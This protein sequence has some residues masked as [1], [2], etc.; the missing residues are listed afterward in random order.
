MST[1]I[2]ECVKEISR[3]QN[4]E[5]LL[6][7]YVRQ[8]ME[9]H[10]HH[11]KLMLMMEYYTFYEMISE[12][13][14]PYIDTAKDN[15]A[16]LHQV[17]CGIFSGEESFSDEKRQDLEKTLLALRAEVTEKMKVLTA[18]IDCFVIYEYVLNRVQYRFE[19]QEMMPEDTVFAQEVLNFIFS[20]KDNVV[21]NDNIRMVL[22]QLPVRMTRK[23]YLD[24]VR[25]SISVYEGSD[26]ASL[27]GH[28]YMFRTCA[29]LYETSSMEKYFTEFVPV[30]RELKELDYE[31]IDAKGYEIYAE[32]I[33]I[34]ASKLN[35]VSDLYMQLQQLINEA[36]SL[37]L[38]APYIEHK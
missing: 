19:D 18:Y 6:P 38:A 26:A 20:T 5:E 22:G 9:I 33:R 25:E 28:L 2:R 1:K 16:C 24:L 30:L 15:I 32:K 11:A 14:N 12:G 17:I 35:D 21:V 37:L 7:E 31:K 3:G 27:D 34:S 8:S 23:H 4:A 36:Y 29:M 13:I 10:A